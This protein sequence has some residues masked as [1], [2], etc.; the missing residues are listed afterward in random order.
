MSETSFV[1]RLC[2]AV[3]GCVVAARLSEDPN[4]RVTLLE[5]GGSNDG[6]IVNTPAALVF[7]IG[8]TLN[9]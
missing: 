9:N 7:M 6:W 1:R 4:V 3:A 8:T 2:G 5:A